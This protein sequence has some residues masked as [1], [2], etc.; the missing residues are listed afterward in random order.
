MNL[1]KTIQF[2]SSDTRVFDVAA[3]AGEW[4]VS[5]A[6]AFAHLGPDEVKGKTR[7]AFANGFLGLASFGRS[8]FVAVAT[9]R[10]ADRD[11]VMGLLAGH[12][13][14][15]HGAPGLDSALPAALE[16]IAFV[17]DLCRDASVGT[18]FA[19]RRMWDSEGR[20]KEE[21]RA[22]KPPSGPAPHA[23]IWTIADDEA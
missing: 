1:M 22:M 8:T 15:V 10:P 6:F 9:A 2:D 20:I 16:E 17:E 23:K 18:V 19:V 13:V 12:F 4:A 14:E 21:F 3:A 7:Q 5:G 11:E